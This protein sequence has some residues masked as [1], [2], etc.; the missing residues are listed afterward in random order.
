MAFEAFTEEWA[1]E[2]QKKLNENPQYRQAAQTWEGPIVFMV[3]KDPAVGLEEDRWIYLDLW[4]GECRQARASLREDL[5]SAP[6]VICG[7]PPTWKQLFDGQLEPISTLMRGRLKLVKGN[8][9]ELT[10]HVQA[11]Q[12]LMKTAMKVETEIPEGL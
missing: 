7:D 12:Q 6:T 1:K 3:E 11:A 4:R 8:M 2:Y 10:G 5:E 9:A